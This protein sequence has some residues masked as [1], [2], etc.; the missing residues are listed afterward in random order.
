MDTE[1]PTSLRRLLL[2]VAAT[3]LALLLLYPLSAGPAYYLAVKLHTHSKALH[4]FYV[5]LDW[6]TKATPLE[7]PIFIYVGWWM[8]L[9]GWKP[10][11]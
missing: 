4:R 1:N 2:R 7:K 3:L 5:P 9:A 11:D 10:G 6:A 8:M